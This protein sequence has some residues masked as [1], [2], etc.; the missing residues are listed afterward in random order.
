VKAYCSYVFLLLFAGAVP[1]GEL[2]QIINKDGSITY[3]DIPGQDAQ[4]F[5]LSTTNS[6]VMPSLVKSQPRQSAFTGKKSTEKRLPEYSLQ[7]IS[8]VDKESIRNNAGKVS[9]RASITPAAK[10]QFQLF[11][12]NVLIDTQ[13]AP[14]FDLGNVERGEHHIQIKFI[15]NSGKILASTPE[16]VFYLHKASVLIKAN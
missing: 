6:A 2:Y 10:G 1:A 13:P 9:V 11:L 15:H 12:D 14:N 5:N 4:A 8:P 7:L 3:T 16:R